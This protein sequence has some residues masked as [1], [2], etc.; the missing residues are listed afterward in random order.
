MFSPY[1]GRG[2]TLVELIVVIIIIGFIIALLLPAINGSRCTGGRRVACVNNMKQIGIALHNYHDAHKCFPASNSL[3]FSPKPGES[4]LPMMGIAHGGAIDTSDPADGRYDAGTGFS[5]QTMILPQIE[6]NN[7]FK[8]LKT[9]SV[10]PNSAWNVDVQFVKDNTGKALPVPLCFPWQYS[11]SAFKCPSFSGEDHSEDNLI[12]GV[13]TP[14]T[15]NYKSA[16]TNYVA[17]GASHR[18]SLWGTNGS[19]DDL[20]FQGGEEHPNGVMYPGSK[21]AIKDIK[22]GTSN[23]LMLCETREI[24]RSAWYEGATAAV[25][26]LAGDPKFGPSDKKDITY[27]VPINA[28][29]NLNRGRDDNASTWYDP[30]NYA[31]SDSDAVG[32]SAWIHGPSSE[33]PGVVNH[34]L[35]DASVKS[36]SENID[37]VLYMHLI[38]RAGG[39]P[40]N[41][42]H[43]D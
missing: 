8:N 32:V 5:W 11:L 41:E 2:F 12:G 38:T 22:D 27:G 13:S 43:T 23:T 30:G 15:G 29:T 1:R 25:V 16:V 6:E 9:D 21:T 17:L 40:V 36:V 31:K 19:D 37:P 28:K 35:A 39:E 18:K 26:G 20:E 10:E 34:V 33:H 14:Y 7:L 4:A 3:P 24:T 42:F